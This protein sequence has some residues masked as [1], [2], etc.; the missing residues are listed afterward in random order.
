[1]TLPTPDK[2]LELATEFLIDMQERV[3]VRK[4]PQ[5]DGTIKWAVEQIGMCLAKDGEWEHQPLPSSRDD[6]F[7]NRCRF[8]TL[9]QAFDAADAALSSIVEERM[10]RAGLA[11]KAP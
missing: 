11:P 4:Q 6:E 10:T 2:L 5:R 9:E 8:D 7:L 1:M 3:Y